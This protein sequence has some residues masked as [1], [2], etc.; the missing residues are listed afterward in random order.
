MRNRFDL[1]SAAFLAPAFILFTLFV[2]FPVFVTLF[3]SMNKWDGVSDKVFIWFGNFQKMIQDEN[4]RI[5]AKNSFVLVLLS[6]AI[7]IPLGLVI[8]Y[9]VYRTG[10]GCK[11]FRTV[12]FGPVVISYAILA[13]M[14][15]I[16]LNDDV[17]AINYVLRAVGLDF[18][19]QRWL[20]DPKVVL[21]SVSLPKIWHYMA[22][23]FIIFLAGMEGIPEEILESARIDGAT[24]PQVFFRIVIPVMWEI[25]SIVII[26]CVTEHLK[27][28]A[29]SWI[30]TWGGPDV[31]SAYIA[32]YMYRLA[33]REFAFGYGSSVAFSIFVYAV[34]FTVVFRKI[35]RRSYL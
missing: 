13:V 11:F 25:I 32:V 31:F 34:L 28:F 26:L 16:L 4:Y 19:A 20:T 24:S 17:G 10:F 33:F 27:S 5:V 15:A 1:T 21:Y 22:V 8:S 6:L 7:H 23:P 29:Y 9:L 18:L 2:I 3:F 30:M 35:A 14:F 12:I